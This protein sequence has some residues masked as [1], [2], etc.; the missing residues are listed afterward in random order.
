MLDTWKSNCPL[1]ILVPWKLVVE[2][3]RSIVEDAQDALAAFA[4]PL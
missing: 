1:S 3:I 2:A 4:P